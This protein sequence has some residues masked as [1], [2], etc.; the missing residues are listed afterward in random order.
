M[1]PLDTILNWM[2]HPMETF[3]RENLDQTDKCWELVYENEKELRSPEGILL[4]RVH[5][6][7]LE[8]PELEMFDDMGENYEE[9]FHEYYQQW[10]NSL[11]IDKIR[12]TNNWLSFTS[13]PDVIGSNHFAT[14]NLRGF[15]IVIKPLKSVSISEFKDIG[16]NEFEVVAPM[17]K[18][19]LVEI[20]EFDEFMSKYGTGNSDYEKI[21]NRILNE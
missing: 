5:E 18:S 8:E 19:T 4:Y 1:D 14:K 17:D 11:S 3:G 16:F 6:G 21:K 7:G 12:W 10:E 13:K 20:L 15:V 2:E 9:I